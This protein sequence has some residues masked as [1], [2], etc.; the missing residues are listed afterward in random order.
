MLDFCNQE[1][2]IARS[3]MLQDHPFLTIEL[4][5]GVAVPR[6]TVLRKIEWG[7][8]LTLP[9]AAFT[10]PQNVQGFGQVHKSFTTFS[11]GMK[12]KYLLVG[13]CV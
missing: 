6:V 13:S 10:N 11:L 5:C 9:L 4:L 8:A 12:V 2:E 3:L 7:D 1:V